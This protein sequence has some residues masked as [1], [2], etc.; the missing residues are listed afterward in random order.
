[1]AKMSIRASSSSM[2]PVDASDSENEND[3][4]HV[5]ALRT[6]PQAAATEAV[7]S[8]ME[9][10]PAAG[11][12]DPD[13]FNSAIEVIRA[14]GQR[15]EVYNLYAEIK[16]LEKPVA[17]MTKF[18]TKLRINGRRCFQNFQAEHV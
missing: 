8:A 14:L 15:D 3:G 5:L 11:F 17:S 7:D 1:M 4:D 18:L 9:V 10:E 13:P 6:E 16:N 2:Y 12:G